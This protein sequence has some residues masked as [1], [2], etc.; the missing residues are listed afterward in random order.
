MRSANASTRSR[1]RASYTPAVLA[2]LHL[3]R[4]GEVHNP[5][6]LVYADLSGFPLS[7]LGRAQAASA[8][9]YLADSGIS[10]LATSPLDRACE[11]AGF[12]ARRLGIEAAVEAGLTEWG[13]SMHWSGHPW[14]DLDQRFPGELAVYATD[15]AHLPFSPESL[16]EVATRL[17]VVVTRLG[18]QHPGAIAAVVSHQDPIQ[19]LRRALTAADR[20][21]RFGSFHIAKPTH[22]AVITLE[23]NDAGWVETASWAPAAGS[24]FPPPTTA[25]GR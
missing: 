1:Y 10:V 9:E 22:A 23:P 3:V 11:T 14:L 19:A 4:H 2:R 13:L 21:G 17:V 24:P 6:G 7:T 5:L 25:T 18:E 8:A 16:D 15:P 12:I 20:E